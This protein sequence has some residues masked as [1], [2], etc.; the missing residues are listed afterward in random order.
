MKYYNKEGKEVEYSL[1][2]KINKVG[3]Y[4]NIYKVEED[5]GIC[6]KE[7]KETEMRPLT[8]F[9]GIPTVISE[10]IFNYFKSFNNPNFCRL[11]ELLYDKDNKIA[12]Y[13]MQYY[14]S[15][16]DNILFMPTAY[17]L[18]NFNDIYTSMEKLARDLVLV[19]D[20]HNKN[21]ILTDD[22]IVLLDFDKYRMDKKKTYDYSTLFKINTCALY[23]ALIKMLQEAI[24]KA[25]LSSE[26]NKKVSQLFTC[27]PNPITL[28]RKLS[29]CGKTVDYFYEKH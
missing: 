20:L 27:S 15:T 4:G 9:D 10:D 25:G 29:G 22:R 21:M 7:L 24:N 6:L 13:T 5:N 18:D 1:G 23:Y 2:E 12:A 28:K 14:K 3:N 26:Y 19:V 16:I 11:Y 17:L 8:I